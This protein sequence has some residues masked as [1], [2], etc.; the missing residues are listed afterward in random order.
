MFCSKF[1]TSAVEKNRMP[2]PVQKANFEMQK[3]GIHHYEVQSNH[4]AKTGKNPLRG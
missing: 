1:F 2:L 3:K 4:T